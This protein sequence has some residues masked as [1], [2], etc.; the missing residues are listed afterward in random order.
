MLFHVIRMT[1]AY[2]YKPYKRIVTGQERRFLFGPTAHISLVLRL[3]GDV[4]EE[5]LKDAV[6]KM[7]ISYPQFRVR[8]EWD[9][10]GVHDSTTEGA[11]EVPVKI[12]NRESENYWIEVLNKEHAI[13][14]RPSKGPLTRFILVKGEGMS[15]L[16]VF[17]HHT[18]SDG[19]SL[20]LALREVLLHIDE[21]S[22]EPLE[23]IEVPSQTLDQF[24]KGSEW[25]RVKKGLVGRINKKWGKEKVVFDEEDL[26]NIWEAMW[27]DAQYCIE[28]IEFDEEET[29]RLVKVSRENGVTL[30][31]T[32]LVTLAKAR[33][34]ALG[35]YDGK[36]KVATAVD[37]RKRLRVDCSDAVG[38]Y[39]GGSFTEFEYKENASLWDNVRAY[40]KRVS[41]DL[42]DNNVFDSVISHHYIDQTLVDAMGA[43]YFGGMIEPHQSRYKKLSEYAARTDGMVAK[44]LARLSDRAPDIIS[45]NL[46]RLSTPSEITGI[47]VERAFFTPSA[48]QKMELVLG[49]ATASGKLTITLNYYPGHIA[50]KNIKSVRDKAEEILRGLI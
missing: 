17:C 21:P 23:F 2:E 20:E 43:S 9:E 26:L 33:I 6:A 4:S 41:K 48:G 31:S 39:A 49:I 29:E 32:L 16:I 18:I 42:E 22:R 3:R 36:A 34:D 14:L 15:E 7:L 50:G 19:R 12:Y 25:G 40:H 10:E 30:N 38:F 24:P 46:G 5:A 37:A 35:P 47:V 11:A 45:T 13:P 8:I 28:I 27:K 1:I 44:Q